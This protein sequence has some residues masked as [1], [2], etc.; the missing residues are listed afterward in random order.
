MA[1]YEALYIIDPAVEEQQLRET[2]DRFSGMVTANGGTLGSVDEWGKRRLAYTIDY[3]NEGFY[4]L[5]KF[6][7]NTD[8]PRELERNF[9][10]SDAIIRYLVIRLDD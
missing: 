6:E 10:I 7:A 2:I 8:F 9:E 4:V 1:K 5:M 3:K